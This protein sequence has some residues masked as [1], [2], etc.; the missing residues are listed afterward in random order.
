[1]PRLR[2]A[3]VCASNQNRSMEVHALLKAKGYQ[4]GRLATFTA[5]MRLPSAFSITSFER[6]CTMV[7]LSAERSWQVQHGPAYSPCCA[8]HVFRWDHM[9]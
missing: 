7:L 5:G 2:Y 3:A 6:A 9:E 1:M 8:L 4:V